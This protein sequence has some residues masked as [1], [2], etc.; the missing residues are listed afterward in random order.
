MFHHRRHRVPQQ[1]YRMEQRDLACTAHSVLVG[2]IAWKTLIIAEYGTGRL[3]L[4][5][6]IP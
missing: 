3:K 6:G 2:E 4:K 5:Q 1:R